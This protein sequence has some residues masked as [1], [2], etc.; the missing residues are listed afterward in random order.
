MRR[1]GPRDLAALCT[2]NAQLDPNDAF[3]R[4]R[5][6]AL[7]LQGRVLIALA[8]KAP[9]GFCIVV[10]RGSG[11]SIHAIMVEPGLRRRGIGAHMLQRALVGATTARC[12]IRAGNVV[13]EKLFL[14]AG[15]TPQSIKP[16]MYREG[17]AGIVMVRRN[18]KSRI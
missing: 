15:F 13:S 17:E 9:A 16:R 18:P 3:T 14:G 4:R 8:G 2:L 5:L 11:V 10:P 6:R 1:A 12:E 7:L